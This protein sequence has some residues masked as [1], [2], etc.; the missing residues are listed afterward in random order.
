[1]WAK[2]LSL[3]IQLRVIIL[4][5]LS[6]IGRESVGW[7]NDSVSCCDFVV[8]KIWVLDSAILVDS[9]GLNSFCND[10]ASASFI[11]LICWTTLC[12]ILPTCNR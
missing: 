8:G 9:F 6:R 11:F 1:L 2:R 5:K 10:L 3:C 7:W 12:L 4:S